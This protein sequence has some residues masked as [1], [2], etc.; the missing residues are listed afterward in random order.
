MT[1]LRQHTTHGVRRG[2]LAEMTRTASAG[3][4]WP[5]QIHR[6]EVLET[7]PPCYRSTPVME[8]RRMSSNITRN[9]KDLF[10]GETKWCNSCRSYLPFSKFTTNRKHSMGLSAHCKMCR[11][12]REKQRDFNGQTDHCWYCGCDLTQESLTV[13]HVVPRSM[14]GTGEPDNLVASCLECN[15]TKGTRSVEEYRVLLERQRDGVPY[16]NRKQ[17]AWLESVGFEFPKTD[18]PWVF[19][20]EERRS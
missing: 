13:D 8:V 20:F 11:N 17:R 3:N 16:F 18:S 4:A 1:G 12:N 19:W 15:Q 7:P 9:R 2:M 6:A 10:R 14:G 5:R